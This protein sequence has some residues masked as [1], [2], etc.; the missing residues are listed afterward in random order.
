M[1]VYE[2]VAVRSTHRE[3]WKCYEIEW[4]PL[5][6][7]APPGV[8]LSGKITLRRILDYRLLETDSGEETVINK[9]A[10]YKNYGLVV[11]Y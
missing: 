9:E 2:I 7:D 11:N 4:K 3:T 8:C 6:E 10:F 5:K 1:K